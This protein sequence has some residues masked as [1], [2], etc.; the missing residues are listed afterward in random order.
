MN[1]GE[2]ATFLKGIALFKDIP[3]DAFDDIAGKFSVQEYSC[4]EKIFLENTV[5]ESL[6]IIVN[7]TVD[8]L[9]KSLD[10]AVNEEFLIER[11]S[12]DFFGEMSIMDDLPRS[13]TIR[14][15]SETVKVLILKK[16]DFIQMCQTYT[17]LAYAVAKRI[18][19]TVREANYRYVT[20]LEER[21]HVLEKAYT[22]LKNTQEELLNAERLSAIGKFASIIIHDIK[23]PLTNIRAYAELLERKLGK[24]DGI[25]EFFFR[26]TSTIINEVDRLVAMTTELLD[27]SKGDSNL[28]KEEVDFYEYLQTSA[29]SMQGR[30]EKN[31][32]QLKFEPVKEKIFLF[33]DKQK[34]QRVFSNLVNNAIEAIGENGLINI[35]LENKDDGFVLWKIKDSGCGIPQKIAS[36]IFEPFVSG[37]SNGTGLGMS[38]VKS[39]VEKHGGSISVESNVGEG[40]EMI[41]SLP[42]SGNV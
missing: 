28:D 1:K 35:T 22:Q 17:C 2:I 19:A 26:G 9:K 6:Y 38:I 25:D 37:K 12:G 32:I 42:K 21:N 23:N 34:M 8:V 24:I 41:I 3:S 27:F 10:S 4:G 5:A 29:E 11:G 40:T 30:A 13:A 7:G 39:F 16:E 18:S 33:I 14:A 31:N 36:R 15:K 20:I